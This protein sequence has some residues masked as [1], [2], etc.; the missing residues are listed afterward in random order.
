MD[1]PNKET[2]RATTAVKVLEKARCSPH[3]LISDSLLR[4]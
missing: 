3:I 4:G 1:K 2:S